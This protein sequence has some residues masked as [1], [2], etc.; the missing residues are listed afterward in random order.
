MIWSLRFRAAAA[1][2]ASQ[3]EEAVAATTGATTTTLR[4]DWSGNPRDFY[5]RS[6]EIRAV[7]DDTTRLSVSFAED[8]YAPD[9]PPDGPTHVGAS[10]E[11]G[12]VGARLALW[13]R[14]AEALAA[15]GFADV[16]LEGSPGSIVDDLEAA[17]ERARAAAMREAITAALVR[18][19]PAHGSVTLVGT[20]PDD[21]GAVLRAY[22]RPEGM[23]TVALVQL[24]LC[25]VPPEL[26]RF[27]HA[28][29][30]S[31]EDPYE[32]DALRGWSFPRLEH[33]SLTRT[34][35]PRLDAEDLRAVPA[36][37][38]LSLAGSPIEALDPAIRTSCPHLA[39]VGL[40]DTPLAKDAARIAAL[41]AAWPGIRLEGTAGA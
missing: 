14:L 11:G 24:G 10:V 3:V 2:T 37:S 16:T 36:L 21:L 4:G 28:K 20:R 7:S 5:V 12:T 25:V 17:G 38:F 33:L 32:H 22:A 15:R 29:L 27:G 39:R 19:V 8:A 23:I 6:V 13:E 31:L 18:I 30:L 34:K 35:A 41:R 26:A 40:W 9:A 1:S